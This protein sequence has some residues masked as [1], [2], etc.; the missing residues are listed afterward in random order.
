MFSEPLQGEIGRALHLFLLGRVVIATPHAKDRT[1]APAVVGNEPD[2]RFARGG[3]CAK[4]L[5]L[6]DFSHSA[7]SVI[8][9]L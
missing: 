1:L 8:R 9:W 6:R 4:A 3:L 5:V 2:Q 7:R